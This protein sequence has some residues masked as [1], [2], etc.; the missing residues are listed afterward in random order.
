MYKEVLALNNL[1]WLI[2]HKIKRNLT[3][4]AYQNYLSIVQRRKSVFYSQTNRTF[5]IWNSTNQRG[6]DYAELYPQQGEPLS[7]SV[8]Q[9]Y[10]TKLHLMMKLQFRNYRLCGIPL[11]SYY[12]QVHS[13]RVVIP[14]RVP[15][16]KDCNTISKI[17][18]QT[19]FTINFLIKLSASTV[20]FF[21]KNDRNKILK[22]YVYPKIQN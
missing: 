3:I 6:L 2:C 14:V 8:N 19:N 4:K 15:S 7:M 1:R 21:L 16:F 11:H 10:D 12:S 13:H 5:Q 17:N 20:T 22:T 9:M 18:L